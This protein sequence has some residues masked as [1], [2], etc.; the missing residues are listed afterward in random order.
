MS[1]KLGDKKVKIVHDDGISNISV[2][3]LPP[4]I[5]KRMKIDFDVIKK[6]ELQLQAEKKRASIQ[7]LE[8]QK[9]VMEYAFS[10]PPIQIPV[11]EISVSDKRNPSGRND[12]VFITASSHQD[13]V[14]AYRSWASTQDDPYFRYVFSKKDFK[15]MLKEIINNARNIDKIIADRIAFSKTLGLFSVKNGRKNGQTVPMQIKLDLI[16]N[17]MTQQLDLK[18]Y[19]KEDPNSYATLIIRNGE[20]PK[21]LN[22]LAESLDASQ[23]A[24]IAV[25]KQYRTDKH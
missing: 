11:G 22:L 10:Q 5:Q 2:S 9:K 24:Y 6:K 17:P 25:E 1:Y 14:I 12:Y 19:P 4:E 23:N 21:F 16:H 20:I 13:I 18:F 7:K 3:E 8:Y 15:L